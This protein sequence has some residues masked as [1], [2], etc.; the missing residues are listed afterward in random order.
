MG[1]IWSKACE[2]GKDRRDQLA[3]ASYV[4]PVSWPII[5]PEVDGLGSGKICRPLP[6][7]AR[8]WPGPGVRREDLLLGEVV[9]PAS[10]KPDEGIE[11][12]LDRELTVQMRPC[13]PLPRSVATVPSLLE[14]LRDRGH[15]KVHTIHFDDAV[16]VVHVHVD[17]ESAADE[18]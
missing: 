3:S 16:R 2:Q 11:A 13:V 4:E 18:G 10:Q 12:S 14:L 9:L 15:A 7:V 8:V 17:R 1:E 5:Q 6:A